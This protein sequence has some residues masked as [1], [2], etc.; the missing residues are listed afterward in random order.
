MLTVTDISPRLIDSVNA[1]NVILK[2]SNKAS[3]LLGI[4]SLTV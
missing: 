2:D 1:L 4:F 3:M